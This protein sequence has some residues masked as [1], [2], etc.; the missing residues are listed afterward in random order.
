MIARTTRCL[1]ALACLLPA[2][3]LLT[4]CETTTTPVPQD[5]S[6]RAVVELERWQVESDGKMLGH[7]VKYEIRDAK[8]PQQFFRVTDHAGR[9]MGKAT[10]NGRFSRRTPFDGDLD[11]GV[12]SMRSGV[13]QLFEATAPVTLKPVPVEAVWQKQPKQQSKR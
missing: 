8:Q 11:L 9:W 3:A 4:S 5:Y 10:A 7:V 12:L 1:F 2:S 13:A 6:A